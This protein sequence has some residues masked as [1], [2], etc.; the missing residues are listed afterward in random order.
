MGVPHARTDDGKADFLMACGISR[1]TILKE[2]PRIRTGKHLQ[3][4][5]VYYAK[6]THIRIETFAPEDH[7]LIEADGNVRGHTP[8]EFRVLPN[9]LR[10]V[11]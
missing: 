4:P 9:A 10:I 1:A 3:N 6:S 8:A 11:F 5:N 2:L 7:L